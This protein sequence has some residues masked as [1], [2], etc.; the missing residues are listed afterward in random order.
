MSTQNFAP[1]IEALATGKPVGTLASNHALRQALQEVYDQ[2]EVAWQAGAPAD[3]LAATLCASPRFYLRIHAHAAGAVDS[4]LHT[5]K[6]AVYS[7]VL[8]GH[9]TNT[10][11]AP[12]FGRCGDGL[13]LWQCACLA[14]GSHTQRRVGVTAVIDPDAITSDRLS[15]GETFTVKPGD[16]HRLSISPDS[17]QPTVTLCLFEWVDPDAPDAF[18]L[19]DRPT[20]VLA[21]RDMT[22]F[23]AR[24]SLRRLLDG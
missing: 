6:G 21:N 13:D 10:A 15:A 2:G 14:D 12:M 20:P 7:T 5:H 18:V 17:A 16:Y 11:A 1:T 24:A 23:S 8:S 22:V 19:T 4:D 3:F 9:I